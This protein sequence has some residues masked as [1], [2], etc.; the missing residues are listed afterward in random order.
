M[1][2]QCTL[3][4]HERVSKAW[5]G[6]RRVYASSGSRKPARV[7]REKRVIGLGLTLVVE[8]FVGEHKAGDGE[9]IL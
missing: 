2:V 3:S 6:K 4:S 8:A 1:S 5:R 9:S 7:W